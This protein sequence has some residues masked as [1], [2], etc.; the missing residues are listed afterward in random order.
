MYALWASSAI[1][2]VGFGRWFG[3]QSDLPLYTASLSFSPC[4]ALYL[5]IRCRHS[6]HPGHQQLVGRGRG[7]WAWPHMQLLWSCYGSSTLC[8]LGASPHKGC[9]DWGCPRSAPQVP[10]TTATAP[11]Q[12]TRSTRAA[13]QQHAA[14]TGA[15]A[16]GD[17]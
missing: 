6:H 5:G 17:G 4:V 12:H 9:W 8:S 14:P 2:A 13:R 10:F 3:K 16:A 11:L 1:E 7:R 15:T